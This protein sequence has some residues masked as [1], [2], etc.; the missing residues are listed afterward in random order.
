MFLF[1]FR[2]EL[3]PATVAS[4][5]QPRLTT[6]EAH[7]LI[8][9]QRSPRTNSSAASHL[10]HPPSLLTSVLGFNSKLCYVRWPAGQSLLPSGT[11][12]DPWSDFY[13]RYIGMGLLIWGVLHDERVDLYFSIATGFARVVILASLN[14]GA[15][16]S[17]TCV[18]MDRVA[19]LYPQALCSLLPHLASFWPKSKS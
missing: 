16:G 10:C 7:Q 4:F 12:P 13:Y 2:L 15:L 11:Y 5:S 19:Q 17:R 3:S 8:I 6:I 18:T 14:S 9:R 1:L